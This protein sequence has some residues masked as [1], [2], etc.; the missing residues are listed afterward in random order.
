MRYRAQE[1]VL[2]VCER[3]AQAVHL[4]FLMQTSAV[5]LT[6][7]GHTHRVDSRQQELGNAAQ[8]LGHRH[9]IAEQQVREVR[10]LHALLQVYLVLDLIH[11]FLHQLFSYE[12]REQK[13]HKIQARQPFVQQVAAQT[14]CACR[15]G[16]VCSHQR[17]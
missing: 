17:Q 8:D 6:P 16:G 11:L 15:W 5:Q 12:T 9:L 3:G 13:N 2:E 4:F 1:M 7:L 14:R 10:A